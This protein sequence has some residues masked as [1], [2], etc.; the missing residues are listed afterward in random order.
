MLAEA[1]VNLFTCTFVAVGIVFL[2]SILGA[3]TRSTLSG[4]GQHALSDEP[5][6][7]QR[8]SWECR[9]PQCAANNPPKARFCGQCGRSAA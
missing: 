6:D 2:F 5:A 3:F 9:N 8:S 1:G 4:H 7:P